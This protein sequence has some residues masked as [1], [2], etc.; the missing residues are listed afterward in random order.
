MLIEGF[1]KQYRGKKVYYQPNMG[2]GGDALIA[3]GAFQLLQKAGVDYEIIEDVEKV[4]LEDQV[5]FYPGGGNL[6]DEYTNCADFLRRFHRVAREIVILPHT[7][8]GNEE[9]LKSLG[10][11]VTIFCREHNSYEYLQSLGLHCHVWLDHDLAFSLDLAR[12][13]G[14]TAT[15]MIAYLQVLAKKYLLGSGKRPV[16]HAFRTDVEKTGID[17]PADNVDV[18]SR[19]NHNY[20]MFPEPDVFKTVSDIFRFIGYFEE[21]HTNRLHI[22]I[23]G[24]LAGKK[25]FLH[26]NSYWKNRAI[27]E[28]SLKGRFSNVEFVEGE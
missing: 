13:N 3:A 11:N 6:V 10:G 22:G 14:Q 28:Y 2:N 18:S 1:L 4:N 9:L 12:C 17:L 27:Y 15:P 25:V 19:I 20:L 21:V 8:K 23:A 26:P 7:V 24:A 16:L 5:V